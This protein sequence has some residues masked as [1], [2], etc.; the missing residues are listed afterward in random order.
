MKKQELF[1]SLDAIARQRTARRRFLSQ[2]GMLSLGAAA[3]T[4]A[5]GAR[6][7]RADSPAERAQNE[8]QDKD[9]VT[10]IFTAALIAEDLA[11]TFYYNGL[12]GR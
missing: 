10:E 5:L 1:E 7:A 9:T 3:T 11:T 6:T 8:E 4:F 12:I 2:A